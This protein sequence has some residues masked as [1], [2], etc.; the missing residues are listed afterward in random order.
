MTVKW[1]TSG[2]VGLS[3]V[4]ACLAKPVLAGEFGD[5]SSQAIT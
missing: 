1:L 3:M 2:V 5:M 4:G